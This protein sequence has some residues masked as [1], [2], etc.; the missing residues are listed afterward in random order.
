MAGS[1]TCN[2][3]LFFNEE[4]TMLLKMREQNFWN[5]K[6]TK[7]SLINYLGKKKFFF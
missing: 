3:V 4:E 6:L 5:Y 7:F 1:N 2:N